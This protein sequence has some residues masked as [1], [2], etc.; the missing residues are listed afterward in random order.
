MRVRIESQLEYYHGRNRGLDHRRAQLQAV[1]IGAGG[2]GAILAAAG[3]EIWIGLTTTIAAA[4]LS[5]LGYLQVDSTIVAYNQAAGRLE[6]LRAWWGALDPAAREHDPA[7]RERLV[8]RGE[9]ALT[10]E[11]GGWVE[12]MSQSLRELQERQGER[13]RQVDPEAGATDR[14]HG[15][16]PAGETGGG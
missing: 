9:A 1:A 11:L 7:A 12:Q 3:A 4:G 16:P 10:T 15:P 5:Y 6:R 8:R 14:A 2:A 13:I